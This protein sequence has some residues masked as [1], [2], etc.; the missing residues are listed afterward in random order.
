MAKILLLYTHHAVS[1]GRYLTSA[2]KRLGHDVRT[3]GERRGNQIWGITVSDKHVWT[4]DYLVRG[5]ELLG[6]ADNWKPDL[7]LQTDTEVMW[8]DKVLPRVPHAIYTVDN[9]V[10]DVVH[11]GYPHFDK[12][13]MAHHDGPARPVCEDC[14]HVWLPCAYD[15]AV[16]TPSP[17]PMAE[18]KYDIACVGVPYPR[19][20][21]IVLAMQDAGLSVYAGLG[22]LY[23]EYRD[24]YHN[25]RISLCVSACGDVAQR[26]F[27][28][29]AMGCAIL[30]DPCADF[31]RLGFSD[32]FTGVVYHDDADAV[33]A[34]KKMLSSGV[35]QP[36]AATAQKWARPH[37][38]ISR[39][40][41]IL[42]I[43]DIK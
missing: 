16:F 26:V 27:E 32:G 10:R 37:T 41:T 23:E 33:Y 38:W 43:M 25:A 40:K 9:H 24:I 11:G 2:F 30:T 14:G 15:D 21:E 22:P 42:E 1:S 6:P 31:E 19:R 34:A 39:C 20:Q 13:L 3:M 4:P 12:Y 36:F 5:D 18:R 17:I 29:A 7:V 28:T 8:A 35:L